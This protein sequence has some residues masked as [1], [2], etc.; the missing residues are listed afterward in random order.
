MTLN[1]QN[2][3]FLLNIRNNQKLYYTN[4]FQLTGYN[5]LAGIYSPLLVITA[6]ILQDIVFAKRGSFEF[7]YCKHWSFTKYF[8]HIVD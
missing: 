4:V 6:L 3:N 2:L 7:E 8:F 1:L 5:S